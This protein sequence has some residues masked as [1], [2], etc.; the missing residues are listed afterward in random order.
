MT[1]LLP[2]PEDPLRAVLLVR[3]QTWFCAIPVST[4]RET[5][6]PLPTQPLDGVPAFVRGI[7]IMRGRTTPVLHLATLLSGV[8]ADPGRR[9]VSVQVG[10][11]LVALELDEA[12]GVRHLSH[13]QLESATPLLSAAR[14][15]CV[16]GLTVLDGELLAWLDT[17]RIVQQDVLDLILSEGWT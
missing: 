2:Q 11:T 12:V 5:C 3:A 8:V 7:T 9:F 10:E 14:S 16:E 6:R 17:T 1:A 4:V 15:R 13:T